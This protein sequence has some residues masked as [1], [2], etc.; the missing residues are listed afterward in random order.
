MR[1]QL[2]PFIH[3]ADI[4]CVGV[5]REYRCRKVRKDRIDRLMIPLRR[6]GEL[7]HPAI[8]PQQPAFP[9]EKFDLQRK[10]PVDLSFDPSLDFDVPA[11]ID[12]RK[13]AGRFC[14]LY[15][16]AFHQRKA[17]LLIGKLK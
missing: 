13:L 11:K 4:L 15:F 16:I 17:S 2:L 6:P 5:D 10:I 8:H 1:A 7:A 14:D 12:Q 3:K 9:V